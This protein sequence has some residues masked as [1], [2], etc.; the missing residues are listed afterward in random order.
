MKE[1]KLKSVK[2]INRGKDVMDRTWVEVE[3]CDRRDFRVDSRKLA[4]LWLF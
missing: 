4:L 2:E 1:C 3:G